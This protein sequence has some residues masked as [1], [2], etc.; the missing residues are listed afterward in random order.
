MDSTTT[1]EEQTR[2]LVRGFAKA[3]G[4]EPDDAIERFVTTGAGEL[5]GEAWLL[6]W[7][8]NSV[9]GYVFASGNAMAIRGASEVLKRLDRQTEQGKILGL[10]RDQVLY[11][12][13]G[14]GIAVVSPEDARRLPAV[15]HRLFAENS[16]VATCSVDARRIDGLGFGAQVGRLRRSMAHQRS[17][18]GP[19]PEGPV[20][21]F[22]LLCTV[23]GWRAAAWDRPRKHGRRPECAACSRA[24]AEGQ[25]VIRR[26]E[27]ET[28]FD[29]IASRDGML[30]VIYLDGNGIGRTIARLDAPLAY[31]RF[32]K[33]IT[34]VFERAFQRIR[35]RYQL[36]DP[37]NS[38]S[39]GVH[40]YQNPISGGDDWVLIVPGWY[41]VPMARDLLA[42]LEV[43]SDDDPVLAEL[44]DGPVGAAA[45]VALG[46]KSLP[47]RHLLDESEDLLKSAKERIYQSYHDH[48][49]PVRSALD[50][51]IVDDGVVRRADSTA[52]RNEDDPGPLLLSGRPYALDELQELSERRNLWHRLGSS[53]LHAMVRMAEAG[54]RQL[55]NHL[56]YQV[57]RQ[58]S[59]WNLAEALGG[60]GVVA[61]EDR[62]F[63]TLVPTV[64]RPPG[65]KHPVVWRLE[66]GDLVEL[67]GHW[68]EPEGIEAQGGTS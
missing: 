52:P 60:E 62:L 34:E 54:P 6:G 13:G 48:G 32:S 43:E 61:E 2:R 57:A 41:A 4:R 26:E 38:E 45:G 27:E 51:G 18:L 33:A 24:I 12:G 17:L 23:C 49:E 63:A 7:D 8:V 40:E 29:T 25:K 46:K 36:L 16:R 50:F 11:A 53:Q 37:D 15:L 44:S 22:A 64:P 35:D 39:P 55:R 19:D 66:A 56:L 21:F 28:D 30:G 68:K 59:W 58:D 3:L 65:S 5:P 1:L 10:H 47:I 9:H 42:A 31:A 20:P 67:A 14:G